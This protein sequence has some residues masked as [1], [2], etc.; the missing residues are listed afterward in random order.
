MASNSTDHST[1][2][3]SN[4]T[5]IDEFIEMLWLEDGLAKNTLEAYRRDLSI[6][7]D[8]LDQTWQCTIIMASNSDISHYFSY[9][10]DQ[11][12]ATTINRRLAVIRRFYQFAL[13]QQKIAIDPSLKQVTAKTAER[14][15]HTLSETQ[16]ET[17][18]AAPNPSTELGLRDLCM[19]ELMYASGLRVTELVLLT[20][21]EVSLNDNVL[22]ITGK[23]NKTRLVPFGEIASGLIARYLS[24]A[25]PLIMKGKIDDALFVT[26]RGTSMTRQM[27]WVLIK[28][29]TKQADIHTPLSPHTLRHAFATHLVNHGA[30][31]RVVQLLLGHADISTTQI[32]THVARTRLKQLHKKHHPRG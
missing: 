28:K 5:V 6:F 21:Q 3:L 12:K 19:L 2:T 17:L 11:H 31:L 14:T 22:R 24:D 16:V 30:D 10:H 25:R 32:Y 26:A 1:I 13:R 15:I 29:Y 18:L 9:L 4:Q 23:G 8:W 20:M 27:F 7:A